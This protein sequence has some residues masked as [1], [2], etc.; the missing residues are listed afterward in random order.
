MKTVFNSTTNR[1]MS[2]KNNI[3]KNM[4][5]FILG[6]FT[7]MITSCNDDLE[8]EKT[9]EQPLITYNKVDGYFGADDDGNAVFI[10]DLYNSSNPNIGIF[11][12]GFC[13]LPSNPA[14][15]K[16]DVGTYHPSSNGG[17]KTFYPGEIYDGDIIGT[18]QYNLTTNKLT[19]ITG[20]SFTVSLSGNTYTIETDFTG[21]DADTGDAVNNIRIK[22][23]GAISFDYLSESIVRSTYK[24]S[25]GT[26]TFYSSGPSTWNGEVIPY[27]D[28]DENF[29]R[30]T[31]FFG[32]E[33]WT[34]YVDIKDGKLLLDDYTVLW[35]GPINGVTGTFEARFAYG[36]RYNNKNYIFEVENPKEIQ[37]DK[38]T[39][40]L[41]FN[42][43]VSATIDG[44]TVNNLTLY[45]GILA[46]AIPGGGGSGSVWISDVYPDIKLK[47]TSISSSGR[48]AIQSDNSES[49]DLLRMI[50][51]S[52][53]DRKTT[54]KKKTQKTTLNGLR[55]I[56]SSKLQP[57][58]SVHSVR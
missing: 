46:T 3:S 10:M 19:Y 45:Y 51:K 11:I 18:Y 49:T 43:K 44:T 47:L 14:N 17:I 9:P 22:Y 33:K 16:L 56:D 23:T 36:V 38:N 27:E 58:E 1:L 25:T 41:D 55:V 26:P 29:I 20:G 37:Y 39:E 52:Y 30:I 35:E 54:N 5:Y 7:V 2:I 4:M 42:N 12:S 21:K 24:A 34:I 31:N 50:S 15:F 8:V 40:T 13:T 32:D 57:A 53:A 6:V 28:E 48:S